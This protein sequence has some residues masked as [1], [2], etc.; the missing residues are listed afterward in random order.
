MR[1]L[2]REA[3]AFVQLLMSGG[4]FKP[5]VLM[6]HSIG[7]N[8][9][10]FTVK[11]EAFRAQ[12]T[13]LKDAGFDVVPLGECVRRAKAGETGKIAALTFDDGYADFAEEAWPTLRA[14]GFPATV[15]LITGRMG[16][17]YTTSTSVTLPLMAWDVAERLQREGLAFGSH[18]AAH[19]ELDRLPLEE[20]R[21]QLMESKRALKERLGADETYFCYPRG[22]FSPAVREA[23]AQAG[24]LGAVTVET[25]HPGPQTDLFA[26]PR[27]YA[28]SEMGMKEFEAALV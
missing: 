8:A 19:F 28:H 3:R 27:A 15:F 23:V 5:T 21:L 25:G 11:P 16:G 12:M 17:T 4:R 26:I 10:H 22:R 20:A 6:Y 7:R 14:L 13:F 24:Y 1:A 2:L 9:A 18:T